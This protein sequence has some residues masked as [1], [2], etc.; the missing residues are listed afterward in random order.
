MPHSQ[1]L[2]AG[3]TGR[4]RY[5]LMHTFAIRGKGKGVSER[6]FDFF[7]ERLSSSS[8]AASIPSQT[9]CSRSSDQDFFG[10]VDER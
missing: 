8:S 7:P 2:L 1:T 5:D 9:L 6:G 10:Q 4:T 3:E